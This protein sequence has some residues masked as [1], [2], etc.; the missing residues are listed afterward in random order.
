MRSIYFLLASGFLVAAYG[1]LEHFGID[2]QY[3]VQDV[4]NRVFSTMGQPNW[5]AAWLVALAPLTW[6]L[7]LITKN[8]EL[9]TKNKELT[10]KK[11]LSVICYL[12][13]VICYICLLFTKSRSG[14]MG[15]GVAALLFF[16]LLFYQK[17]IRK[18]LSVSGLIKIGLL[19]LIFSL[20]IGT[21]Y[22]PS[23]SQIIEKFAKEAELPQTETAKSEEN[24]LISPSTDIRKVVWQGALLVWLD[25]PKTILFGDGVEVFGFS[26]Y[27]HRPVAHNLLSEWD[28]LYNKAH[29]EYLNFL[30]NSGILGL[31][32]Y[33]SIIAAFLWW[34]IREIKKCSLREFSSKKRNLEIKGR[35][36]S[37]ILIS[38]YLNISISAGYASILVTNFFGFSVVAVAL[39]FFLYPGF[40]FILGGL[41]KKYYQYS[42]KK[43]TAYR[44]QITG[45]GLSI[46]ILLFTVYCLLF[47]LKLWFADR[48]YAQGKKLSDGGFPLR[49]IKPLEKAV[50]LNKNQADFHAELSEAAANL[51]SSL[52]IEEASPSA[53]MQNWQEKAINEAETAIRLNPVHLNILKSNA[54]AYVRLAEI[55]P[56][57]LV[58]AYE[59]MNQAITLAPT[60]PRVI[61]NQALI[62]NQLGETEEAITLLEQVVE[63]KSNY[64]QAHFALGL[65]LKEADRNEEAVAVFE[66]ILEKINPED[67]AAKKELEILTGS[68]P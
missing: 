1:I 33:L 47:T 13:F 49:A 20:L 16:A 12:L 23:F 42:L 35:K 34:V 4:K 5:L 17:K 31:G 27:N 44:L 21:E 68:N 48:Y 67:E 65:L 22:T 8:R 62:L 64:Y 26:Y 51:A 32:S 63:L 60:E 19:T 40:S 25:N 29:N 66:F 61:Y 45:H 53:E 57:F 14:L 11:W 3:W 50:S 24:L 43:I 38:Q 7:A 36:S 39:L 9:I 15:F 6:G 55:D 30:A 41:P 37:N 52:S 2:E 46:L 18:S 28:F 10:T 54:R 58:K 59:T 56:V